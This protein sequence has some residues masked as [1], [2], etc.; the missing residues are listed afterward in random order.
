M[1]TCRPPTRAFQDCTFHCTRPGPSFVT[2][3]SSPSALKTLALFRFN[4]IYY[5]PFFCHSLG[6]HS[7]LPSA[8]YY[9]SIHHFVVLS[10]IVSLLFFFPTVV[11]RRRKMFISINFMTWFIN[12]H[13][14]GDTLPET[15]QTRSGKRPDVFF[16]FLLFYCRIQLR[17]ESGR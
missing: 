6:L 12:Q 15:I 8:S 17:I 1:S 5:F 2:N 4:S 3:C 7:F 9:C 11:E 13:T 14:R 16:L 10:L